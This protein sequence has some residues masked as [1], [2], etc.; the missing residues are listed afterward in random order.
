MKKRMLFFLTT[1]YLFL[2]TACNSGAQVKNLSVPEFEKAI[3]QNNVQLLDVRTAGE[4][5]SG[6]L[7]NAMLANWNNETEFQERV[8]SLDKSK[9]VYAY[10]LAGPRSSAAT[11][12]LTQNGFTA[13]NLSGGIK[14]WKAANKPVAEA[15]AAKQMSMLEYTAQIPL[16]K[17]VLVDFSATWC[18]P[19]RKMAPLLDSLVAMHGSKFVLVKIDGAAQTDLSN[20]LK[21]ASFPTFFIYKQGKI[22]WQ[23]EGL[24][25]LKEFIQQL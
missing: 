12:W 1:G 18:P 8:K 22:V 21:V 19:C 3:A 16:D 2:L 23:K 6:H 24:V 9:P 11:E 15:V 7:S 10:C 13:Y 17:T 14:A 5:Q 20:E 4:Y 25:D